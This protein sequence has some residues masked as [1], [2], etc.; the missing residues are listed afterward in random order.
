MRE[1]LDAYSS[2]GLLLVPDVIILLAL[3]AFV[4][5]SYRPWILAIAVGMALLGIALGAVVVPQA[6]AAL[7]RGVT[8]GGEVLTVARRS[9]P[10]FGV[11][12]RLR[13]DM[14]G[15]RFEAEY[16][17]A[18]TESIRAGDRMRILIDPKADRVMLSLGLE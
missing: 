15:R 4:P 6:R 14:P 5:A 3:F 16:A 9:Y 13:V 12:G 18:G 2:L 1:V 8:A 7:E 10:S 17:W 11:G